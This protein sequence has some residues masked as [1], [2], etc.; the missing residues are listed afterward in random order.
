MAQHIRPV[1]ALILL[2]LATTAVQAQVV[3][4]INNENLQKA[5]QPVKTKK[6][7]PDVSKVMI[8]TATAY[9]RLVDTVQMRL[10]AKDWAGAETYL[11]KALQADPSNPGN[12]LL[13]SNLATVQRY[14]GNLAGAIKNY[15]LALDLTPNAVTVLSN[16]AALY[17]QTDSIDRA[18][19]DYERIVKIDP[20][21]IEA[22]Y[23]LG[24]LDLNEGKTKEA[25]QEFD[26]VLRWQPGAVLASQGKALL[27]K[28]TGNLAKA[29]EYY[30]QVINEKPTADLLANRADC[31]LTMHRLTEASEDIGSALSIDPNDGYIYLLRAKLNKLRYESADAERDVKLAV[32]H[33]VDPDYAKSVLK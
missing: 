6:A 14:Q 21:V 12:S 25:D 4:S 30:S 2:L 10:D 3:S 9:F 23:N 24:I 18:R 16:R 28:M 22:H 20:S 32:Q 11:R 17:L 5:P 29:A 19:A 27:C 13:L 8:D 7:K 33:G 1:L 31:Y 26:E 15:T